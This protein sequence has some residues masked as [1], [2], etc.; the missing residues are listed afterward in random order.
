MLS[1]RNLEVQSRDIVRQA[2]LY[3]E[4]DDGVRQT[5]ST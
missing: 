1:F 2:V 5:G 3:Q 4:G